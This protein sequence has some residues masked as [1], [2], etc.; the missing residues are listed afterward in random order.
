M[1][2][3]A[4]LLPIIE[5]LAKANQSG[6]NSNK[7]LYVVLSP[8]REL[9]NQITAEFKKLVT[10]HPQMKTQSVTFIG[11]TSIDKDK[12]AISKDHQVKLLVATPGRL[13]DHLGQNTAQIVERLSQ[14]DIL[15]LD[16]ADRLLGETCLC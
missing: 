13:L 16:E 3:L 14:V 9:A 6:N 7:I 8:T 2:F 15:C 10:F 4:F 5:H 12:K 1:F 11:G